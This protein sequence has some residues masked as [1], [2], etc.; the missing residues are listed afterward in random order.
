M[1]EA[2]HDKTPFILLKCSFI[3][4]MMGK[5]YPL[6]NYYPLQVC[7]SN[8]RAGELWRSISSFEQKL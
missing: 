5:K 1:H 7:V 3:I 4:W 6:G 2:C 8:R